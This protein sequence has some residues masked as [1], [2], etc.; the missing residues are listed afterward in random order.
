MCV[1]AVGQFAPNRDSTPEKDAT[2]SVNQF[3]VVAGA[4][5]VLVTVAAAGWR[6]A[7]AGS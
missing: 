6:E 7:P 1:T 2:M 3:M 4:T 5:A